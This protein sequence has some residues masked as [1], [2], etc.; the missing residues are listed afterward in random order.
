MFATNVYTQ[1]GLALLRRLLRGVDTDRADNT[2][3]LTRAVGGG[4]ISE[5]ADITGLTQLPDERQTLSYVLF[6]RTDSGPVVRVQ[7]GASAEPYTLHQIGI[8]A[9]L[10][11]DGEETLLQVLQDEIG[12]NIPSQADDESFVFEIDALTLLDTSL[13]SVT[14]DN[15]AF[16]TTGQL[17]TI[18]NDIPRARDR[19]QT[20]V[21]AN[22]WR[23]RGEGTRVLS[24]CPYEASVDFITYTS[25]TYEGG[26]ATSTESISALTMDNPER[27]FPLVQFYPESLPAALAAGV[28]SFCY[29][30]ATG[31]IN[32][33]ARRRPTATLFFDIQL[34]V[35]D[36]EVIPTISF[37]LEAPV[38]Q[39]QSAGSHARTW[40]DVFG[41]G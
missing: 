36:P 30:D 2:L 22:D 19:L 39:T 23:E 17:R 24:D 14:L 6:A 8:Y 3:I 9:K 34:L 12:V 29:L 31:H 16:V 28:S 27:A 20:S 13:V 18:L 7:V 15:S 41:G 33:F 38:Q 5:A 37:A 21:S 25:T 35:T 26:V 40:G 4:R 1:G 32:L 10:N 11:A